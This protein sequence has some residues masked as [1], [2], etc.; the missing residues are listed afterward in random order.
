[1]LVRTATPDAC[2]ERVLKGKHV[3]RNIHLLKENLR[4][5]Q[6]VNTRRRSSQFVIVNGIKSAK[7]KRLEPLLRRLPRAQAILTPLS[8]SDPTPTTQKVR[9]NFVA[10]ICH[11][12]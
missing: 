11:M 5:S 2:S 10:H 6:A 4:I 12:V 3:D 8:P 7:P 1:M 9:A